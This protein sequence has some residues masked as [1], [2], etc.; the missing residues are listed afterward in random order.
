[1][2]NIRIMIVDDEDDLRD[3]LLDLL[4]FKGYEV[5][6]CVTGEEALQKF[7]PA[8]LDLVLL[9]IQLPGMDGLMVLKEIKRKSPTLPVIMVSASSV[10]GVQAKVQEYGADEL[11]L[12]PYSQEEILRAVEQCLASRA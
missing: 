10:R 5:V 11:I 4:E 9:D 8:T 6:P 7:D 2:A 12:K 1:M 3:N